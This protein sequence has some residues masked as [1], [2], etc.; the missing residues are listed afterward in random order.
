M[1]FDTEP[2]VQFLYNRVSTQTD[3]VIEHCDVLFESVLDEEVSD[4]ERLRAAMTLQRL[5][6]QYPRRMLGYV[7][8]LSTVLASAPEDSVAECI[9]RGVYSV[10]KIRPEVVAENQDG[11]R[12]FLSSEVDVSKEFARTAKLLRNELESA[13]FDVVFTLKSGQ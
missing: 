7:G 5:C 13:G 4:V 2:D 12:V 11:V 9:L 6:E 8:E 1:S 10:A 3:A